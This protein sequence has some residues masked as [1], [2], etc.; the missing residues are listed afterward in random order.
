MDLDGG[1]LI[2]A[3]RKHKGMSQREL[4]DKTGINPV[5]IMRYEQ[6][7]TMPRFDKVQWCLEACGYELEL[8]EKR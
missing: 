2:K 4:A 3:C 6:G 8:R 1:E 5:M 7:K